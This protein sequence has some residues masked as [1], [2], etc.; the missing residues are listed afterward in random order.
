[1]QESEHKHPHLTSSL[2]SVSNSQTAEGES[3]LKRPITCIDPDRKKIKLKS[4]S[5]SLDNIQIVKRKKPAEDKLLER[6][7]NKEKDLHKSEKKSTNDANKKIILDRKERS[8][9]ASSTSS[10]K[11]SKTEVS[12]LFS[13][14]YFWRPMPTMVSTK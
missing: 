8:S 2:E 9:T 13:N 7:S 6:K 5:S 1:M 10:D 4:S 3:N 12:T 14:G 11:N